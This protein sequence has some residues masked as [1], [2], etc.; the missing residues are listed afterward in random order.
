MKKD[1]VQLVKQKTRGK[2]SCN[3]IPSRPD[4]KPC[5]IPKCAWAFKLKL[6]PDGSPL[7][8]KARCCVRRDLQESVV[9]YLKTYATVVQWYKP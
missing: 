8:Y 2:V 6:L 9:D 4:G 7:K 5:H 3:D 1:I